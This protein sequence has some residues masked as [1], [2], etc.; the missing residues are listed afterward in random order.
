MIKH[1][2]IYGNWTPKNSDWLLEV[3]PKHTTEK[4]VWGLSSKHRTLYQAVDAVP[5]YYPE[6]VE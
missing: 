3:Q 1:P 6:R 4:L 2:H 5:M